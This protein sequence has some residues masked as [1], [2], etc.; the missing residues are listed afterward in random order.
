MGA[1]TGKP[2]LTETQRA[3]AWRNLGTLARTATAARELTASDERRSVETL[4]IDIAA[5]EA[6]LKRMRQAIAAPSSP[7][8]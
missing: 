3:E 7:P 2:L 6:I 5:M 4:L 8:L 1:D